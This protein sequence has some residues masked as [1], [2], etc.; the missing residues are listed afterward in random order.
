ML[1]RRAIT[2]LPAVC[3]VLLLAC[4]G[5]SG[6]QPG[7]DSGGYCE[8]EGDCLAG[9]TCE[10]NV[11]VR[12]DAGV[13]PEAAVGDPIIV[14]DPPQADFGSPVVGGEVVIPVTIHNTGTGPL[15]IIDINITEND[16]VPEYS[17]DMPANMTIPPSGSEALSVALRPTDDEIDVGQLLITSNDPTTPTVIVS[18]VSSWKGTVD[19]STCVETG[20][21]APD[22]CEDPPEISY[23]TI[24]YG[25]SV[26]RT[27]YLWNAG[28]G[29]KLITV[30]DLQVDTT[31]A[32]HDALYSLELFE[33]VEN[34]PGSGTFDEVTVTLPY[35]LAPQG[36]GIAPSELHGRL[37][38]DAN[39]DGFK[40]LDGDSLVVTTTN[41]DDPNN[42]YANIP[43]TGL[44][45]GCP[46][47]LLDLNN[48]PTDGCEYTC[49]V[50][51]G[52]VEVC[53]NLDNDCDGFVDSFTEDC[54]TVGDGGCNPDGTGCVGRCTAGT[55][56]CTA[57]VY[58][59]C[60]GQI[61]KQNEVC[62]DLDHDCDGSAVNGLDDGYDTC[63]TADVR[64]ALSDYPS[65]TSD[66]VTG[67]VPTGDE[68]WYEIHFVDIDAAS[69]DTGDDEF[70][71]RLS[72][73]GGPGDFRMDVY[74]ACGGSPLACKPNGVVTT[75]NSQNIT[76]WSFNA[77]NEVAAD[78]VQGST[79]ATRCID[80]SITVFVRVWRI[81][82]STPMCQTYT[83]LA[84]NG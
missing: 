80:H 70:Y 20:N 49:Q 32:S 37:T 55:R 12:A 26:S 53:D 65:P 59:S 22:D 21:A 81:P 51:G 41:T 73:V 38:F 83:L 19:L 71:A 52:G 69:G 79:P 76:S 10:G 28:D 39:T 44:V 33:L 84:E 30:E 50:T 48:D 66:T 67:H 68:D 82:S 72:F 57:G 7:E 16:G 9:W 23:G 35:F 8:N 61:G 15:N 2:I 62:D 75:G 74:N 27:F 3:A 25:T 36:S 34:P 47:G 58:S 14:V 64:P 18:L 78:C 5:N 6:T 46:A 24:T 54:Y 43:I 56:T 40:I 42:A 17:F 4:G 11:C 60:S 45:E 77:S 63:N 1:R 13:G 31:A 29:N